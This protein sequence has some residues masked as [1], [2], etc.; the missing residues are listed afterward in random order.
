[1]GEA[2]PVPTPRPQVTP[3]EP[4]PAIAAA[5]RGEPIQPRVT[6]GEEVLPTARGPEPR[7]MP[8]EEAPLA[9]RGPEPRVTEEPPTQYGPALEA[10]FPRIPNAEAQA[11]LLVEPA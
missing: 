6:P 3:F 11:R 8:G 4:D 9:P 7:V 10:E 1:E 2:P 5:V